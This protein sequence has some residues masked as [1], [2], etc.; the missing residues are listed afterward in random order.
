VFQVVQVLG[1]LLILAAFIASQRGWVEASSRAYLWPNFV[2]SA[3][4]A[5]QAAIER[6]A[7]FLL[8]EGVWALVSLVGLLSRRRAPVH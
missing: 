6:Q 7:G 5:A 4:L 1:S 3:V 8:L 2:G